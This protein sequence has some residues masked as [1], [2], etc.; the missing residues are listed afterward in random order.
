MHVMHLRPLMWTDRRL[1][2]HYPPQLLLRAVKISTE[3]EIW[4][5]SLYVLTY[6]FTT[7]APTSI[8]TKSEIKRP[9]FNTKVFSSLYKHLKLNYWTNRPQYSLGNKNLPF[10]YIHYNWLNSSVLEIINASLVI[11]SL[12]A[13][14]ADTVF[15][16]C[17]EPFANHWVGNLLFCKKKHPYFY[18]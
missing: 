6:I 12:S 9:H 11:R 15:S 7:V 17:P 14:K 1:W 8:F 2:K 13:H 18:I 5:S 10:W 3:F 4:C 16:W